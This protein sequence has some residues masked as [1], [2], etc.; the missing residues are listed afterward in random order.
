M[1]HGSMKDSDISGGFSPTFNRLGKCPSISGRQ[2]TTKIQNL[3]V[4]KYL[5]SFSSVFLMQNIRQI[6]KIGI[7]LMIKSHRKINDNDI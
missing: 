5:W 3:V 2:R 6:G 1:Q 4:D 7:F